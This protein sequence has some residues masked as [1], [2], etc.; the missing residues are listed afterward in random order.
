MKQLSTRCFSFFIALL[1]VSNSYGKEINTEIK[2]ALISESENSTET[3]VIFPADF[4]YIKE[5]TVTNLI[6]QELLPQ[7]NA[8]IYI[9]G[10]V[11]IFIGKNSIT[12]ALPVYLSKTKKTAIQSVPKAKKIARIS[13][14]TTKLL[15]AVPK[16]K[17]KTPKQFV[18]S[19]ATAPTTL[20]NHKSGFALKNNLIAANSLFRKRKAIK[21]CACSNTPIAFQKQCTYALFSRPPTSLA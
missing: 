11:E 12:N 8:A 15:T 1:A 21:K 13:N 14:A 6:S 3:Q 18:I 5:G 9:T 16:S 4:F 17:N 10:E 20:K 2:T 19:G 7:K